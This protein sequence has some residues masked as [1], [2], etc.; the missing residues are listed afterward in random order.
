MQKLK[1][2]TERMIRVGRDKKTGRF[3]RKDGA[4]NVE[5]IIVYPRMIEVGKNYGKANNKEA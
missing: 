5:T 3:I 1:R 2:V 4:D